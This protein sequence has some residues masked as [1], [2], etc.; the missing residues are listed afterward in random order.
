MGSDYFSVRWTGFVQP[1]F[2]ETYRFYVQHDDTARLWINNQLVVSA[3]CCGEHSGTI[4][5]QEGVK[6]AI[7]L[8]V[9]EYQA[10]AYAILN[11]SSTT[12]PK[13]VIPQSQ[14]FPAPTTPTA[15]P[16][17]GQG[18]YGEYFDNSNFT[19]FKFGRSDARV[20]FNW[21]TGSPASG[22][23]ADSFSV[24]WTG[25]VEPRFSETYRF[26]VQHDD[27]IRLWVNNQ[28]IVNAGCCGEHSGLI[29]LQEGEK[30]SIKLEVEEY[31]GG[32]YAILSWSSVSQPKQIIPQFQL[33]LPDT[34][35]E[36][37][38]PTPTLTSTV[39][40]VP[41]ITPTPT[42][43]PGATAVVGS[44][45]V[46][47]FFYFA[48]RRR[49]AYRVEGDLVA[50]N[51][52]LFFL[53]I[54]H[55][56][57]TSLVLDQQGTLKSEIRYR[58]WG[59]MRYESGIATVDHQ[60]TGQRRHDE[61]GLYFYR[62]RWYDTELGRFIQPDSIV[63]VSGSPISFDRFAYTN[64][65]P[66]RFT[67]PTGHYI[68]EGADW[69]DCRVPTRHSRS[70]VRNTEP[71]RIDPVYGMW[72]S[73][74]D[75]GQDKSGQGDARNYI[76]PGIDVSGNKTIVAPGSGWVYFLQD[77]DPRTEDLRYYGNFGILKI[78][79]E[80]LPNTYYY[81]ILAHMADD[82]RNDIDQ[83]AWVEVGT[84]LGI[85]G[86]TGN[87]TGDHL[88][89]EIRIH[90]DEFRVTFDEGG[91]PVG[92]QIVDLPGHTIRNTADKYDLRYFHQLERYYMD[93]WEWAN[94]EWQGPYDPLND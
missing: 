70:P 38:A 79:H 35:T 42:S 13:E 65:N 22:M 45:E 81:H 26:Y 66:L 92:F 63:P 82:N 16:A 11:W 60:F 83:G 50:E 9:E 20:N 88:H 78:P 31:A 49:I 75:F 28:L 48:N 19:N 59:G 84:P 37:P 10:G 87:S 74:Y 39:T 67:D 76:H 27:T 1:R 68:C 25:F 85:I 73:G 55:L 52:G 29:A 23:G 34:P 32:A 47:N 90:G 91:D 33:F 36:T 51:N 18:V 89:W 8:E 14:L 56:G 46:W 44:G 5:L 57:S 54:D 6:Y 2:S 21:G 69:A 40:L 72:D 62:S 58:A 94:T 7:R 80:Q 64:N 30:Y 17:N 15:T 41:T 61:I 71:V 4:S 24:R 43:T 53:I 86:S 93:P 77:L 12:Q 3:G